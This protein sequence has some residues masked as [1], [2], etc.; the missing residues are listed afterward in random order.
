M[1]VRQGLIVPDAPSESLGSFYTDNVAIKEQFCQELFVREA[2]GQL[3][4]GVFGDAD[5][6]QSDYS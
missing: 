2:G 1:E 3:G 6:L 5:I 4:D